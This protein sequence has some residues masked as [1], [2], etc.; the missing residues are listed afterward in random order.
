VHTWGLLVTKRFSVQKS[1]GMS[2]K[3]LA[4]REKR[5][6]LLGVRM[7]LTKQ[8]QTATLNRGPLPCIHGVC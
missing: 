6:Y 2:S 5:S 7:N 3:W 8:I 4:N 1:V